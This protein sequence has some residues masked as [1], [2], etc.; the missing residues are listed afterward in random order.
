[1]WFSSRLQ[2]WLQ[3]RRNWRGWA[4]QKRRGRTWRQTSLRLRAGNSFCAQP[5]PALLLTPGLCL[6]AC[7]VFLP[8]RISD[9]QVPFHQIPPSSSSSWV[10]SLVASETVLTPSVGRKLCQSEPERL[11]RGPVLFSD[12]VI[13]ASERLSDGLRRILVGAEEWASA[14]ERFLLQRDCP[15]WGAGAG[16]RQQQFSVLSLRIAFISSLWLSHR[17][18]PCI[19]SLYN[20]LCL[21]VSSMQ[22]GVEYLLTQISRYFGSSFYSQ[23]LCF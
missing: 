20:H 19:H 13:P 7:T 2:P 11:W 5:C 1:M 22:N 4:P 6:S 8:K 10:P 18:L 9:L 21:L 15:C 23:N 14:L 16:R 12:R 17:L 3:Q